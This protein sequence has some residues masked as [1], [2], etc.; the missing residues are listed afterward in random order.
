MPS[1]ANAVLRDEEGRS[2]LR[3]ERVLPHPPERVWRALTEP[4][5]LSAWHPTPFEVDRAPDG[6]MV[7]YLPEGDVPDMPD[8]EVSEYEPP[9]VLAHA[10]GE[11][12]LR[13]EL[14]PHDRGCLL[15]LAHTFDDRFKA[16]RDAAGWHLC[17]DALSSLLD[18]ETPGLFARRLGRTEGPE[19]AALSE[20]DA[21]GTPQGWQELN[22]EYE[23]R[24]GIP[25]DKATPPPRS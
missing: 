7:R 13:W 24:F 3:F 21:T 8:G 15:V 16:A 11:D 18:G 6:S 4:G 25:P 10:W 19:P 22:R 12:H 20:T 1:A 5:E 17:L 2:V 23:E 9:R 14:R